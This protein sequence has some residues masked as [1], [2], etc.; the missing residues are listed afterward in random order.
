MQAPFPLPFPSLRVLRGEGKAPYIVGAM[1]TAGY[2]DKAARLAASCA[3][4]SLPYELHEVPTVHRSI[5]IKGSD[6]LRFTKANFIHHLLTVHK[7]PVLYLDADCEFVAA[8]HLLDELAR[9][10]IDF[11]IYNWLA[12]KYTDR[13]YPVMIDGVVEKP[14]RYFQY[15]GS[16]DLCS[17]TQ[18]V[19][20]G[21]TQFYRNSLAARAFL[22][23]WHRTVA[24]FPGSADDGC[25]NFTY[26]NLTK[27]D[28]LYWVL[29]K[30]WLP[31]SYSRMTFWIYAEPV[32]NHA[33]VIADTSKFTP[34]R[35]RQG[36]REI[37]ASRVEKVL[38]PLPLPRDC[39]IDTREGTLCRLVEGK[40]IAFEKTSQQ[41]WV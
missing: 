31:K 22:A 35:G 18:L 13:F 12:D 41:F 20:S 4:F 11:A 23:R 21:L 8:P 5:S 25:L 36:R 28:W 1:F 7:K 38:P 3:K 14:Y 40:F 16:L 10:R 6:D 9:S 17:T 39:I 2:A 37:Y 33:D 15:R 19:A 34:V 29:K 32:I 24:S 27:R 26:N 30:Y